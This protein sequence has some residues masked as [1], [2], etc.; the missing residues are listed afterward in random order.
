MA[1]HVDAVEMED[2]LVPD[3]EVDEL[4]EAKFEAEPGAHYAPLLRVTED[5]VIQVARRLG[6]LSRL[7]GRAGDRYANIRLFHLNHVSAHAALGDAVAV[8]RA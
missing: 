6:V 3:V 4:P 5:R 7:D 1:D 2:G 8:S